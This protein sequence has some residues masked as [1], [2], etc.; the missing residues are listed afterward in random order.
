MLK[1]L[2]LILVKR[3]NRG[4]YISL[5]LIFFGLA[6][7]IN[8]ILA[9]PDSNNLITKN[10]SF[11]NRGFYFTSSDRITSNKSE[12]KL[13]STEFNCE[14][15]TLNCKILANPYWINSSGS[16]SLLLLLQIPFK[17][18]NVSVKL[19]NGSPSQYGGIFYDF[20]SK[21]M[22]YI[23]VSLPKNNSYINEHFQDAGHFS[24]TYKFILESAFKNIN[25]FT[26]EFPITWDGGLNNAY[27]E[28]DFIRDVY[29]NLYW[30]LRFFD[31]SNAILRVERSPHYYYSEILPYLD[32]IE[33]IEDKTSY[34][35][36]LAEISAKGRESSVIIEVINL[37]TKNSYDQNYSLIWLSLGVGIPTIISSFN[38]FLKNKGNI[39]DLQFWKNGLVYMLVGSIL[40]F[41]AY[42]LMSVVILG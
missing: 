12:I 42:W 8:P 33:V 24:L 21:N 25:S 28:F 19:Q 31:A 32:T 29:P 11:R 41:I 6:L 35:W 5:F 39:K 7:I 17:I 27:Q 22:S 1:S 38:E 13:Y 40:G 23:F 18:S 34:C 10:E 30:Q 26:Y 14:N 37:V 16:P 4:R 2:K 36:D 15:G 3:K 9:L 20:V